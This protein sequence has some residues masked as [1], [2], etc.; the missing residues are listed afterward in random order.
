MSIIIKL[1]TFQWTVLTPSVEDMATVYPDHAS[2]ARDGR[3]I[4]ANW[5]MMRKEDVFL[6]VV[7]MESGILK[8]QSVSVIRDTEES[9]VV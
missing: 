8:W 1:Y 6:T 7:D 5:W 3:E 2:V 9:P 4:C